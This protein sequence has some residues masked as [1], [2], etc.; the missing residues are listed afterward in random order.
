[1]YGH[2]CFGKSIIEWNSEFTTFDILQ[3]PHKQ[4]ERKPFSAI[5]SSAAI[6]PDHPSRE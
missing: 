2:C 1:L 3:W 4:P 5:N 6:V